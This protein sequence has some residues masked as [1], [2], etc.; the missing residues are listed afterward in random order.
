MK[1]KIILV[2]LVILA[3]CGGEEPAPVTKNVHRPTQAPPKPVIAPLTGVEKSPE[4]NIS[5][6]ALAIKIDNAAAARPQSGLENADIVYEELAEGGIT[7]FLAVFHSSDASR[8]GPVRSARLV[9]ADILEEYGKV[10][11]G[12]SGA[13]PLVL[14]KI[15]S[16]AS[17]I[18]LR[19]GKYGDA[20]KRVK[21]RPGPHDLFTS[22]EELWALSDV[23]S[24]PKTGLQFGPVVSVQTPQ[25]SAPQT[26][27]SPGA[28]NPSPTPGSSISFSFAGSVPV[29]YSYDPS[30]ASYLRFHGEKP[31][32]SETNGQLHAVNVVVL[33]VRTTNGQIRDA[34]GNFSPEISVVGSGEGVLLT[35]GVETPLR[36]SRSSLSDNMRLTTT[37]GGSVTLAPGNTWI[38]LLPSD[39]AFTVT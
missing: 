15:S 36:W 28:A 21:G 4:F 12:Y 27:A 16:T 39:R 33:K 25:T 17:V 5:R 30:I 13:N 8:V 2:A 24:M 14:K 9:D 22:T 38:H 1:S 7:R 20:Y 34:A 6:P 35:K 26:H 3:A 37:N 10:L 11:L 32:S 31:H 23:K 18:D 19:H 29:R